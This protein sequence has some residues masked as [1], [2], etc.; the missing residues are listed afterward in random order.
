MECS[1]FL[2]NGDDVRTPCSAGV[3]RAKL[4]DLLSG[5]IHVALEFWWRSGAKLLRMHGMVR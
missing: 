4:Q 3:Y 2:E 5:P 1:N